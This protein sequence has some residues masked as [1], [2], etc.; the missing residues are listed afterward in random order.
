MSDTSIDPLVIATLEHVMASV[1]ELE[2][3]IP[4]GTW[5][6]TVLL[7]DDE[8]I[9]STH[10]EY[11]CINS[12]TDVISFPSGDDLSLPSGYLGDIVISVDTAER[13]SFD[14]GH[15]SAREVAYLALHGLLH[16]CGFDD[17]NETD[18]LAMLARQSELLERAEALLDIQL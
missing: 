2:P 9:A 17:R 18:R 15:S 14:A 13:Q 8:T 6:L 5:S 4:D 3:S 16:L 10:A 12:P 1:S 7:T 11:F